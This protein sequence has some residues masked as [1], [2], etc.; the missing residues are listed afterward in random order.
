MT[1]WEKFWNEVCEKQWGKAANP[2]KPPPFVKKFMS[3]Y[4]IQKIKTQNRD[5][6]K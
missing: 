3:Q 1:T 2:Y 5:T 4:K 6:P